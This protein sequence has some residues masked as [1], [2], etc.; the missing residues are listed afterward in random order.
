MLTRGSSDILITHEP[1]AKPGSFGVYLGRIS[2]PVSEEEKQVL[3]QWNAVILDYREP[4]ILD[5]VSHTSVALGPHIIARIDL[6]QVLNS[7]AG[8]MV[9][10]QLQVVE[11]I[12][13]I[14]QGTLRKPDQQRYFTGVLVA[15]WRQ[16]ISTP[17][18]NGVAKIFSAFG[19]DVFLEVGPPEFIDDVEKLDINLFSGFIVRNGTTL[20]FG[21]RRDYFNM[22]KMKTTTKAF[23]SQAC[24][25][26]FITMIWDT[27]ND[28]A[29]LSHAV[30]RRAHMWCNYHGAIL[31]LT[32][33]RALMNIGEVRPCE[34]PLAA[35]QWLKNRRV[36]NVH[37]KYR[38]TRSVGLQ[39]MRDTFQCSI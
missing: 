16:R 30:V 17:L 14:V 35:F 6:L 36:M 31:H 25:R 32:R 19:F 37:G 12:S 1:L 4:G 38:T 20:P 11:V 2:T 7:E 13:N 39:K 29:N 18:L 26:P 8:D 21:E 10:G 27:V 5:A 24:Q 3:T 23:V 9:A 22:D 15:G 33:Q 34:E 28:E